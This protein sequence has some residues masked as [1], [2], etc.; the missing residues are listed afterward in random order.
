MFRVGEPANVKAKANKIAGFF[1]RGLAK[2]QELVDRPM[3]KEMQMQN[4][5]GIQKWIEIQNRP[6]MQ[7]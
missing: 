2:F 5:T 6:G 7:K 1:R 3:Q 4:R